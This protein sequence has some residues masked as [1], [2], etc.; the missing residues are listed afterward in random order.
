LT[1]AKWGGRR[2][3][4]VWSS[5]NQKRTKTYT[6]R[7]AA[8]YVGKGIFE[9]SPFFGMSIGPLRQNQVDEEQRQLHKKSGRKK[10]PDLGCEIA[11]VGEIKPQ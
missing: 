10:H 9:D 5:E 6:L 8:G 11:G 2:S 4:K 1:N 3:R 7:Q